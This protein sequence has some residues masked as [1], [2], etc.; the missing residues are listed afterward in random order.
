ME[1]RVFHRAADL[2]TPRRVMKRPADRLH[3]VAPI[4]QPNEGA[5]RPA[6]R[7]EP[8]LR[9]GKSEIHLPVKHRDPP[10]Q[11]PSDSGDD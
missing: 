8:G 9:A 7:N 1:G 10:H 3:P 6:V 4:C 11:T 2:A 5:S